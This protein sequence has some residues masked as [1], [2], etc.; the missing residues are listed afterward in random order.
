M[1]KQL[2]HQDFPEKVTP[3]IDE[4]CLKCR[5]FQPNARNTN[6]KHCLGCHVNIPKHR[7]A[8]LEF[9]DSFKEQRGNALILECRYCFDCYLPVYQGL[10]FKHVGFRGIV[11]Q[12]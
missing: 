1:S 2:K 6:L 8:V 5:L 12:P 3:H 7:F 10:N 11:F 4:W 9:P